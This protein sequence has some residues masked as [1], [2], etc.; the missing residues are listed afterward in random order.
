MNTYEKLK[1]TPEIT[2]EEALTKLPN[3]SFHEGFS[4]ELSFTIW[5]GKEVLLF[6][7]L[8]ADDMW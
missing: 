4:Y 2:K 5:N 7:E 6:N 3:Y 8:S 1:K